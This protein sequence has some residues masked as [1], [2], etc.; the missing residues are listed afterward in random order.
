ME[1][2]FKDSGKLSAFVITFIFPKNTCDVFTSMNKLLNWS[3]WSSIAIFLSCEICRYLC[4]LSFV[5]W[6]ESIHVFCFLFKFKYSIKMND[7]N[8]T[9]DNYSY[10]RLCM[11]LF[12]KIW[13]EIFA[14]SILELIFSPSRVGCNILK[15][16]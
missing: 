13:K 3:T 9:S 14:F 4:S 7:R 6:Y 2:I 1:K 15:H 10:W 8:N 5:T 12:L 11:K 16:G